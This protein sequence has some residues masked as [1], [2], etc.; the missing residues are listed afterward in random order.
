MILLTISL[1]FSLIVY[2]LIEFE[3][4]FLAAFVAFGLSIFILNWIVYINLNISEKQLILTYYKEDVI[5]KN[6]KVILGEHDIYGN[7]SY[8]K[9]FNKDEI[10]IKIRRKNKKLS[11][12]VII[13][14]PVIKKELPKYPNLILTFPNTWFEKATL[15]KWVT[16]P[17][18]KIQI[19]I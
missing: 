17:Y 11:P 4:S 2:R 7:K 5:I 9:Y 3:D 18:K 15:G 1:I 14:I 10:E 12:K 19:L 6:N 16:N 13:A 8:Y